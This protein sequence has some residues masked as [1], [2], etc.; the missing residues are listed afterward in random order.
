LRCGIFQNVPGRVY[1][2]LGV[3]N[4]V[5]DKFILRLIFD[6][7]AGGG[8]TAGKGQRQKIAEGMAAKF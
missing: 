1:R 3:A 8:E 7:A 5:G 4:R 6:T 2:I